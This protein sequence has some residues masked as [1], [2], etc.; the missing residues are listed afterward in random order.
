MTNQS[1]VADTP[2][3]VAELPPI[4][5]EMALIEAILTRQCARLSPKKQAQFI[6]DIRCAA[7]DLLAR[8]K[9]RR[10][11]TPEGHADQ[12]MGKVRRQAGAAASVLSDV[13][14]RRFIEDVSR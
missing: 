1:P 4:T 2:Y 7:A 3:E 12:Q 14:S 9:V 5:W 6:L 10:L 13:L 11:F 8:G